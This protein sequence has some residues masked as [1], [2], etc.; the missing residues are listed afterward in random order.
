VELRREQRERLARSLIERYGPDGFEALIALFE[1]GTS[2]QEIARQY[3]T[4]RMT[5]WRWRRALG[6]LQF[7]PHIE[8]TLLTQGW[9]DHGRTTF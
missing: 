1:A 9:R 3:E 5:V 4:T 7:S 8:L 2:G 6:V